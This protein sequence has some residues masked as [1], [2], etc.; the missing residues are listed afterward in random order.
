MRIALAQ[1]NTTVGD[2]EGNTRKITAYAERAETLGADM[3]IFPELAITGYPPEDLLLKP[4]FIREGKTALLKIAGGIKGITAVVG[5]IDHVGTKIYNAAAILND[6][7]VQGIYHK[8]LLPNYGVFD[9]KRYFAAGDR[10]FMITV[11]DVR[12]GIAVCED[13]WD[14]GGPV[15]GLHDQGAQIIL[16]INASPYHAGKLKE[17]ELIIQR[18]ARDYGIYVAYVN[19]VGGQDE[20]VFDGYSMVVSPSTDIVARAA[21]FEE[22][23][24][25]VDLPIGNNDSKHPLPPHTPSIPA[26]DEGMYHALVTGVR[27]YVRK[28]GFQQTV[29]GLSGGIDSSIVA[30]VAVDA[31]G[32]ENVHG[33]F[34]PAR[35]SSTESLED[36]E[37]LARNLG[38]DFRVIPIDD[39]F[40]DYLHI[41]EP[42]FSEK[43]PDSTEENLQARIRGNIMMALSNKFG[44]M[45]LTTGN[46]SEMSTGYATLYGDMAG[47]FAVI[48]DV[49]KVKVYELSHYRNRVSPVIPQRVLEKAPTA[50]LRPNQKDSDSLPPYEILD[51]I[52]KRYVE[53]DRDAR[54]IIAAGF[55]RATVRRVLHLVDINEYKRRQSP[56]GIKIS[57]R[58]FGR[59]RRMPITNRYRDKERRNK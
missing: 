3:V 37:G 26:R 58:A 36:A 14:I 8:M 59:D 4:S 24:L 15:T 2:L 51:A 30:A 10:P 9:E 34:M 21:G 19:L 33:V 56:P 57:P 11:N 16:T 41:M 50:E 44:W 13:I 1:I 49:Y 12:V 23:L 46:K 7:R 52:L 40:S 28:N 6:G 47:G 27:D 31:L 39:I 32:K 29:I 38:I 45:V 25:C 18:V 35:Y 20:L 22:E 53:E 48:K 43:E 42:H 17:R 54:E 55:D 5:C